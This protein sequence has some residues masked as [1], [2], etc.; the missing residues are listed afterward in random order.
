MYSP[1]LA[2]L[3]GIVNTMVLH[4]AKSMERHGIE[5]FDQIRAKLKKEKGESE[6][7]AKKP[8]IYL[9]GL[10][11]NQT[12]MLW[13]M[14]SNMFSDGNSSYH[15][16]MF[17]LGLIVVMLYSS[18]ILGETIQ[19]IEYV[20]AIIM[21]IGTVIIGIENINRPKPEMEMI[22]VNAWILIG[23]YLAIGIIGLIVAYKKNNPLVTGIIFGLFA[24]GSG[25]MD[26]FLKAVG[27][28]YGVESAGFLPDLLNPIAILIFVLSFGVGTAAFLITQWGFARDA[29]ASVLVPCYNS[30]YIVW[31]IILYLFAYPG[32]YLIYPTTIAG[33]MLIITG[34]LLMQGFKRKVRRKQQDQTEI[35]AENTTDIS[36]DKVV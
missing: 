10:A 9:V 36:E 26:P 11:L 3:F 27:Q 28:S 35:Y 16:S 31:P 24:G 5:V 13:A 21:I 2:M 7:G 19:K 6:E 20:G 15:T 34:I 32:E 4:L 8:V 12:P 14:L 33:L 22:L 29:D 23:L 1:A 18:R 17:G 25:G 30:L